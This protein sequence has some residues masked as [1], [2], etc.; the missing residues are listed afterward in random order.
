MTQEQSNR[1]NTKRNCIIIIF[2]I[3]GLIACIS[4]LFPQIRRMILNLVV[5]VLHKEPFSY[6]SSFN[7]LLSLASGGICFILFFDYCTLTNQGRALVQKVK[8]EIID[9]L[10]EI[11]YKVFVKPILLMSGIYLLGILTIIRANFLYLDDLRRALTGARIWYDYSRYVS[12]IASI[13]VHGDTNITDISPLPQLIA[14]FILAIS[15]VLLVYVIGNRKLTVTGSLAS[16]P[17]G[18]SPYFLECLSFKFDAPYFALSIL[19]S[20]IPFLFITRKKAFMFVSIVSLLVMCMTYQAASG[21]YVMI[22][23]FLCFKDWSNRKKANKEILSFAGMAAVAF[24][25]SLL[26][27]RFFI[28]KSVE[29]DT[30]H[31][32]TKMYSLN[33]I[34]PGILNNIKDYAITINSDLSIIWKICILLIVFFFIIRSMYKSEHKKILSFFISIIFICLSFVLSFGAYIFL[35][36]LDFSPRMLMGFGVFLAIICIYVTEYNKSATLAV[37]ALNWCFFVFAFSYGNALADQVRYTEFRIGLLLH[38]LSTLDTNLDKDDISIQMKSSI[39]YTPTVMNIS[40]HAPVIER[41]VPKG[42]GDVYWGPNY[43]LEHYNFAPYKY[44]F[45]RI[46]IL[47]LTV[48]LDSYYHTIKSDGENILVIIKH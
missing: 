15:G 47:D 26:L 48:V 39:D 41:L 46:D 25:S 33:K 8:R 13:F 11:D 32:L 30:D 20:I 9:C 19:A 18:L 45:D 21:I 12:E 1:N 28:M 24:C 17:L 6:E 43:C 35:E 5:Q 14:I 29:Y 2:S 16:V 44:T 37:L 10:S 34:I 7:H 38:D 31:A 4:V 27:F 23:L 22:V 42:L 3:I 36:T 40:K